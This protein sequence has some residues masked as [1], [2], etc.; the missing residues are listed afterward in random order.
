MRTFDRRPDSEMTASASVQPPFRW[1]MLFGLWLVYTCFGMAVYSTAPLVE[2]IATD[3]GLSLGAMGTVMGAWPLLY[4]GMAVPAGALLDRI[5][6]R[7]GMLIAS[8]I[9]TLSVALRS[10]ANGY[11]LLFFAV[12]LFGVGGPLVSVGAPKLISAWFEGK[13]RG[14]A[15]GIYSTGPTIGAVAVLSL[16]NAVFM[17][18]TDHN[19]RTT[20]L[21]YAGAAAFAGLVWFV[22]TTRAESRLHDPT[23]TGRG[24]LRRQADIF[25]S[26]LRLTPVRYV[27][28]IAVGVF[29]FNHALN[30]WLPEILKS[31]GMTASEAGLWASVP[32][33]VGTA[34]SLTLPRYATGARRIPLL[35]TT[36]VFAAL[37]TLLIAYASG[38][39]L[40]LGLVLQGIARGSMIP[41]TMF[42]LMETRNVDSKVMGA[43]GGLFFAA[44]ET[45]GVIGPSMTGMLADATGSFTAPLLTLTAVCSACAGLVILLDRSKP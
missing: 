29:M 38:S 22:I 2:P 6:V 17:P 9:I 34:A 3:L 1:V 13:E 24:S 41:I 35:L 12:A 5:G 25:A 8:I 7:R 23:D 45:G 44:A 36:I 42:V 18:M 39:I 21:I 40:A 31:G 43:A 15:I 14:L 26:L 32:S 27:L 20:L 11:A 10:A 28:A 33:L 30:N 4:I 37:A 16:T 19:W